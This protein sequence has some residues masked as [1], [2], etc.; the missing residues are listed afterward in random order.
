MDDFLLYALIGGLGVAIIAGPLGSFVVWRR[1]A[2]F[3]DTLAHSRT[4]TRAPTGGEGVCVVALGGG[5]AGGLGGVVVAAPARRPAADVCV[6]PSVRVP[7]APPVGVA[8]T[9]CCAR[10]ASSGCSTFIAGDT[11]VLPDLCDGVASALDVVEPAVRTCGNVP[12]PEPSVD[13]ARA[14]G[15]APVSGFFPTSAN[16]ARRSSSASWAVRKACRSLG[17]KWAAVRGAT[18]RAKPSL[19]VSG[20]LPLTMTRGRSQ[21]GAPFI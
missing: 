12:V 2:Y 19:A 20:I 17:G 13:P 3:G 11:V 1:M 7:P 14:V 18:L 16:L 15:V 4:C 10:G 21:R 9:C 8:A 5:L 6:A